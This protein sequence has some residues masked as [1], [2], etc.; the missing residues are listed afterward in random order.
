MSTVLPISSSQLP[1]PV[2]ETEKGNVNV[3]NITNS[4]QCL[5]IKQSQ[6]NGGYEGPKYPSFYINVFE[7]PEVSFY[8]EYFTR[9]QGLMSSYRGDLFEGG[10]GGGK[11]TEP[12]REVGRNEVYESSVAKHGDK[13]FQKFQK[14][15]SICPEQIIR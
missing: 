12:G 11:T 7:N 1:V 13:T 2:F 5:K 8:D 14:E 4:I 10:G 9:A 3:E 6:S 15:L